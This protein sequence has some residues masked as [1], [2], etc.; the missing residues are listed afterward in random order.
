MPALLID[1]ASQFGHTPVPFNVT[2]QVSAPLWCHFG[3]TFVA[4]TVNLLV[5]GRP[6]LGS[7]APLGAEPAKR[8]E[9]AGEFSTAAHVRLQPEQLTEGERGLDPGAESARARGR[10]GREGARARAEAWQMA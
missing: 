2:G 1:V 9:L 5:L 8:I 4:S 7:Y 10:E 6:S 3:V